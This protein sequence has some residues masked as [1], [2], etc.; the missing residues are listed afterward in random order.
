MW[1]I[2]PE[3]LWLEPWRQRC[4]AGSKVATRLKKSLYGHQ[5]AGQLHLCSRA[6]VLGDWFSMQHTSRKYQGAAATAVICRFIQ[7]YMPAHHFSSIV[8]QH[9]VVTGLHRDSNNAE[10]SK[11]YRVEGRDTVSARSRRMG[12]RVVQSCPV[13]CTCSSLHRRVGS[14]TTKLI[15]SHFI[16][17]SAS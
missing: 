17:E 5:L 11:R 15:C 14:Y 12:S 13:Q 2:L 4:P 3:E 7:H 8:A 10:G 6:F 9:R 16:P 1:V